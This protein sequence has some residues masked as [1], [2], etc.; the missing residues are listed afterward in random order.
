MLTIFAIPKP[1]LGSIGTIQRN[2]IISWT[3]LEPRPEIILF[4]KDEGVEDICREFGLIH[5]PDIK[6]NRHGTPLLNFLFE[7]TEQIAE[8]NLL[9]YINPDVILMDD[10]MPAVAKTLEWNK[11]F[12]L[13]GERWDLDQEGLIDYGDPAWKERLMRR[14]HEEAEPHGHGGVDYF[15]FPK[16][17]LG[18]IPPFAVGRKYYDCWFLWKIC[19]QNIPVVDATK[20]VT[21][22]HQNHERTYASIGRQPLRGEDRLRESVEARE[23]FKLTGGG[24][25]NIYTS[26]CA[27]HSLT[28]DGMIMADTPEY[29]LKRIKALETKERSAANYFRNYGQRIETF[30]QKFEEAEQKEAELAADI[31]EKD[32]AIL[33]KLKETVKREKDLAKAVEHLDI[34]H[35]IILKEINRSYL[36]KLFNTLR[37][38]KPAIIFFVS[39]MVAACSILFIAGYF[40]GNTAMTAI[41][42][43]SLFAFMIIYLETHRRTTEEGKARF[44][45]LSGEIA[46][47]RVKLDHGLKGIEDEI[48]RGRKT[49]AESMKGLEEY[50]KKELNGTRKEALS[51]LSEYK[52]DL[53]TVSKA[54]SALEYMN[55][56][57]LDTQKKIMDTLDAHGEAM[58][59]TNR[60][61]EDLAVAQIELAQRQENA[62]RARDEINSKHTEAIENIKGMQENLTRRQE[63]FSRMQMGLK[64]TQEQLVIG[65]RS[66]EEDRRE[67]K[68][69]Q[70][71]QAGTIMDIKA[72]QVELA[73][74]QRDLGERY[75]NTVKLQ[76]EISGKHA[77]AIEEVKIL[78][79][80]II[81]RQ[82]E[83]ARRQRELRESQ[84]RLGS[85]QGRMADGQREMI[86]VQRAHAGAIEELKTLEES[87]SRRQEEFARIQKEIRDAQTKLA[88]GQQKG[89]TSYKGLAD[90][91]KQQ[92][93]KLTQ[94]YE[95]Q[96]A[97]KKAQEDILKGLAAQTDTQKK[98]NVKMEEL[99][100][101]SGAIS[102]LQKT[103][104]GLEGQLKAAQ[105][106][107][108]DQ[109]FVIQD[110][111]RKTQDGIS[112]GQKEASRLQQDI[113]K[114]QKELSAAQGK[115]QDKLDQLAS[116]QKE[117]R[118]IQEEFNK[119]QLKS[120][121]SK[122]ELRSIKQTLKQQDAKQ[123]A[124][125]REFESLLALY[126][127]VK[128]SFPLPSTRK[129]AISP[130]FA[131]ILVKLIKEKQPGT[132]V[133]L[134]SGVSTIISGYALNENG[135]GKI[136][137]LEEDSTFAKV[138]K[139]NITRHNLVKT[140]RVVYAPLKDKTI[141]KK[142]WQWYD[143]SKLKV[144][145]IDMLVVDG[146]QQYGRKERMVRYPAL[147]ALFKLLSKNAII[148][149][150][151]AAREDEKKIIKKWIK[152]YKL[153]C[154]YIK[155]EKGAAVL[156]R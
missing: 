80:S 10:F 118:K 84:E 58:Y 15:I 135:K 75:D 120:G 43:V 115:Q 24:Y 130:D 123:L 56:V 53:E 44:S 132:I 8:N 65:Q 34:K 122:Q 145:S 113:L 2:S 87:I 71:E 20:T 38:R 67:I 103:L 102:A 57:I 41:L 128:P 136:V 72:V 31:E 154:Q 156:R 106:E 70:R 97:L 36:Q 5:I 142:K 96:K 99:A 47:N 139:E 50:L 89:E 11:S 68:D 101:A 74:I 9:G 104:S 88:T 4:G 22:I 129:S 46:E 79:E 119:E 77:E 127:T 124:E 21:C 109:I 59:A 94:L 137:S 151:D 146:P 23:N 30:K 73:G 92:Q 52:E 48:S 149:V 32:E 93:D 111:F 134:G 150:D 28:E 61:Q 116:L 133:E 49:T 153:T 51:V 19:S 90:S 100:K 138:T 86:D 143:T 64:E 131:K 140:A 42:G 69:A 63:E 55:N 95:I 121:E 45:I 125:Y 141:N 91:Q 76:D 85:E 148:L 35:D 152:E 40:G 54:Q 98:Q 155:T 18:E 83:F 66:G 17:A 105:K 29:L 82:D 25:K 1:F 117:I 12:M 39:F 14:V 110:Q 107:K 126:A 147:P 26:L 16:G 33:E 81:R 112:R 27:T 62:E 114:S 7:K 78:Q 3:L 37:G 13:M 144:R 60:K 6:Y 108:I